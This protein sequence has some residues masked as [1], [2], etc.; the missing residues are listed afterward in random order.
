L[1]ISSTLFLIIIGVATAANTTT[2]P[3]PDD[4]EFHHDGMDRPFRQD[5]TSREKN[6]DLL[7]MGAGSTEFSDESN[8]SGNIFNHLFFELL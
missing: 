6:K 1:S 7:Q 5:S 2:N 3:I 8:D 4:L